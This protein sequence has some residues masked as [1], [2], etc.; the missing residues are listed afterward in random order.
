MRIVESAG[1]AVVVRLADA[2]VDLDILAVAQRRQGFALLGIER[3]L[4]ARLGCEFE[5][6]AFPFVGDGR[7]F[8]DA[9]AEDDDLAPFGVDLRRRSGSMDVREQGAGEEEAEQTASAGQVPRAAVQGERA[10]QQKS[11]DGEEQLGLRNG[12]EA[13]DQDAR[14]DGRQWAD[15]RILL[16]TMRI[17]VHPWPLFMS[18]GKGSRISQIRGNKAKGAD[19]SL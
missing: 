14:G 16:A 2:R 19:L 9:S 15:Q 13:V 12:Q 3:D 4:G 6:K 17:R 5:Q 7:R 10:Q 18:R 11:A 1:I 8:D